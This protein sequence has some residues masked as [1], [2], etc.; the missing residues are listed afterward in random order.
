MKNPK[1]YQEILIAR[2]AKKIFWFFICSCFKINMK[3][4]DNI[5]GIS[6]NIKTLYTKIHKNIIFWSEESNFVKM[7]AFVRE[8]V[9]C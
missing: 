9:F 6:T 1:N 8:F 4:C 3:H 7:C 5:V 2:N